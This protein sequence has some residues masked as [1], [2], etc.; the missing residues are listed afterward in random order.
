MLDYYHYTGDPSYNDVVIQALLHDTNIGPDLNYMPPEHAYEEGNDDLFFWGSAVISAAE[1]NFPQPNTTLPSWLELGANVFNSLASRWDTTACNGGL[2]WQI[3]ASNPNGLDYKNSVSNGGFFQIAARMARAT[4][5]QTYLD[6]AEKIWDWSYDIG[7]IDHN[8]Y[9]VYDGA[10]SQQN[11]SVINGESFTYTSG[12]YMYGAAVLANHTHQKV[13][14]QRTQDLVQGAEWFFSPFS[15]ATDVLY[16]AACELHNTCDADMSTEKG[17]LS[18]FM[19]QSAVMVPSIRPTV[20]KYMIASGKAAASVCTGGATGRACGQ[21][22]WVAGYDSNT[23]LGQEMTALETIQGMLYLNAPAPI[24]PKDI[25][26]VR[27]ITWGKNAI[28]ATKKSDAPTSVATGA[29]EPADN[30]AVSTKRSSAAG[31]AAMSVSWMTFGVG[32]AVSVWA[33]A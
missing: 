4:G 31:M 26:N 20:E 7:F 12:I 11:C 28:D 14:T 29:S 33:M 8:S 9:H 25:K 13:W 22:W 2:R 17:Y 5:N 19:W 24:T 15:N 3:L 10:S 6:W 21:R 32:V 18:R 23:G 27:N 30:A 1:R 16:E